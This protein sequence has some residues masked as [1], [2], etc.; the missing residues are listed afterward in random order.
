MNLKCIFL[1]ERTQSQKDY[2]LYDS[3]ILERAKIEKQKTDP[4]LPG[5]DIGRGSE[6]K[7]AAHGNSLGCWNCSVSCM[8]WWLKGS[9]YV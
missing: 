9:G 5:I 2:I 7:G 6:V 8:R 4:W 1:S 3:V